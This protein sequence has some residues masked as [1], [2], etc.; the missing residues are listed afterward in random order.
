MDGCARE[1]GCPRG[2]A[3]PLHRWPS[4][5]KVTMRMAVRIR[6]LASAPVESIF[7]ACGRLSP[8]HHSPS[9]PSWPIPP[10]DLRGLSVIWPTTYQ[11][12]GAGRWLVHAREGTRRHVPLGLGAVAQDGCEGVA[13]AQFV[14]HGAAHDV[15]FDYSD[16]KEKINEAALARATCYFKFQYRPGGYGDPKI[17]PGGYPVGSRQTYRYL[18]ALRRARRKPPRYDVF[19][20]FGLRYAADV[21]RRSVDLLR[22]EPGIDFR[23]GTSMVRYHRSLME[24][25]RSRVCL[26]M[27]GNGDFCFRLVDCLA[28][29]ACVVARR[30]RAEFPVPLVDREHVVYCADDLSDLVPLCRELIEDDETRDRIGRNARD[31]FDQYLHRDQLGSYYLSHFLRLAS[32]GSGN[33]HPRA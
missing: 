17:L 16:H 9:A 33:G 27:P 26:D 24:A 28:I 22:S 18:G 11:W 6:A 23:G 12:A 10:S 13:V 25:A 21:R 31:Y 20:R 29:G 30:P 3:T 4:L 1:L 15:V 8:N 5:G 19:A 7:E 2:G 14:A 32:A